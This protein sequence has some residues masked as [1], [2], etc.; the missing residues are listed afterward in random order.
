MTNTTLDKH[1]DVVAII[2]LWFYKVLVPIAFIGVL[3][4][5]IL[6]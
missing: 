1:H 6:N 4:Y 5:S 2:E 3:I